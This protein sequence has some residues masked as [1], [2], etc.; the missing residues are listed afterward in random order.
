MADSR[1][2]LTV[3]GPDGTERKT[4]VEKGVPVTLG[5]TAD[6]MVRVDSPAPYI[7]TLIGWDAVRGRYFINL[8]DGIR[9]ELYVNG[10][11]KKLSDCRKDGS[12][13]GVESLGIWTL[14]LPANCSGYL[15]AAGAVI[16]FELESCLVR[17]SHIQ[18]I[19]HPANEIELPDI[20]PDSRRRSG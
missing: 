12:A 8:T 16:H 2:R 17:K 10:E 1:L 20:A 18:P 19:L 6:S 14:V 9:G 7:F 11:T 15:A 4:E 13:A 5:N 3:F